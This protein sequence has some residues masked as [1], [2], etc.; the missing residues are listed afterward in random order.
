MKKCLLFVTLVLICF[1]GVNSAIAEE[2]ATKLD[3][4]VVT[5]TRSKEKIKYLPVKIESIG[6]KEIELTTGE[7]ITEQLKK[8]SSIGVIEYPGALAGI[9][10]RGFRPEFSGITKHSLILIDGRPAGAT[11]LATIL[12]DNIERIEVLKGPA[13]SLY[14]SEA[15]GG[16]INVITKKNQ[17]ELTGMVEL[18]YGSF[19][20]A[21]ME[22][23]IGGGINDMFDFDVSARRYDQSDDF[24]MGNGHNRANTEYTTQNGDF[25]LGV[26]LGDNWRIDV[27]IDG[28]QGRNIEMPGDT[29]NGD[30]K[31][32]HKDIDRYGLDLNVEGQIT[33]NNL[34]SFTGYRTQELSESYK[35]YKGWA[36][37][38]QV[39][40]YQ[41]YDSEANWLGFQV[42]DTMALGAHKL[43]FGV[44]YQDIH[45]ESRS[46]NM[47][48]T[49]K[50][51]YAPNEGRENI[52]GYLETI[53]SFMDKNLTLTAGARYDT[54]D[55]S[56]ERTQFKTGF[57]PKTESFS[58]VSPR[59]GVNYLF[60]F[61]VR[62]HTTL[63]KGFVPPTAAQL[64]GYH[65]SWKGVVTQGNPNLDPESSVTY[66]MGV[67]YSNSS[68]GLSTDITYFHTDV[69]DKIIKETVGLVGTYRNSLGAEMN[70]L[71]FMMDFDIGAPLNWDR[72]LSLF[73]NGT[74]YFKAEKEQTTGIEKDIH[75][76]ASH[77]Y[78][79][80]ISYDDGMFD[81]KLH[82][83]KQG[84][85]KD[86]DWNNPM[87]PEIRYPGFTV[88]DFVVGVSF[89]ENHKV[90]L[91]VDNILDKDYYEKKGF[92]KPGRGFFLSYRYKF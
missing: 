54:F 44:D 27:G 17:D 30:E 68:L 74:T 24:K 14:G 62:L 78:N 19:D 36:K 12:C 58:T 73:F 26:N 13:S 43:I 37:P 29:F 80:G 67:G 81:A 1:F 42:K 21:I 75:N 38:V 7:T 88:V 60:D 47:D 57:N 45:K 9:G 65:V 11:N 4:M 66:D 71:E 72:S 40:P 79:Y 46:Y 64:A 25:R 85:M 83:R 70:G 31:S 8:N 6:E 52:A 10:I 56:T 32:G 33:P 77:T 41:S 48:G 28:Y 53:W 61:G 49:R 51:P 86:T 34:L 5:G 92:P 91:K 20:T 23:A 59:V 15:M 63:G 89:L 82:C 2:K 3:E 55:V 84:R 90:T 87:R 35:H 22:A 18:G 16:V 76:V 50:A 69:K 39:P